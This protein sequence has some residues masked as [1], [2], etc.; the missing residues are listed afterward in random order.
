MS[1]SYLFL[2]FHKLPLHK[3]SSTLQH[4]NPCHTSAARPTASAFPRHPTPHLARSWMLNMSVS[5]NSRSWYKGLAAWIIDT[6][7][8]WSHNGVE[9]MAV[10]SSRKQGVVRL[11][12]TVGAKSCRIYQLMV[13]GRGRKQAQNRAEKSEVRF[14]FVTCLTYPGRTSASPGLLTWQHNNI[15]CSITFSNCPHFLAP[16]SKG[17]NLAPQPSTLILHTATH[18]CQAYPTWHV[19]GT[20]FHATSPSWME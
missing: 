16:N 20:F 4:I 3:I 10:A 12:E 2:L 14:S 18:L 17:A 5:S 15:S 7:G 19:T 13:E 1:S 9:D 11:L 6:F 8:P